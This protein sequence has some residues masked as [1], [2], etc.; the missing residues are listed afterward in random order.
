MVRR[1]VRLG[2]ELACA[3]G[4]VG[5]A[6]AGVRHSNQNL[7]IAHLRHGRL[8]E[9]E[10]LCGAAGRVGLT[11]QEANTGSADLQIGGSEVRWRSVTMCFIMAGTVETSGRSSTVA[12]VAILATAGAAR[13][14]GQGS[15]PGNLKAA[16]RSV[17]VLRINMEPATS[18]TPTRHQ[19]SRCG[20]M[21]GE[22]LKK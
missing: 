1:S 10:A 11:E 12:T 4:K 16:G 15:S 19:G 9:R 2:V 5:A 3:L 6:H 21:F 7:A 8:C 22:D 17:V 20:G 14:A 13:M 18:T